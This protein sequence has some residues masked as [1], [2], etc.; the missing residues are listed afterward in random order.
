MSRLDRKPV[1][2][3]RMPHPYVTLTGLLACVAVALVG[4]RTDWQPSWFYAVFFV[5][6]LCVFPMVSR[7]SARRE[8]ERRAQMLERKRHEKVLHLDDEE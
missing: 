6:F 8:R 5:A 7:R 2:F 4:F 1:R 3:F